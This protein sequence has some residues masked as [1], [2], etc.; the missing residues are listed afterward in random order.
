MTRYILESGEEL[1]TGQHP[2]FEETGGLH[3][4]EYLL[5]HRL[6]G[7][8][9]SLGSTPPQVIGS[10]SA[11]REDLESLCLLYKDNGCENHDDKKF[12]E[13]PPITGERLVYLNFDMIEV[14]KG[15]VIAIHSQKDS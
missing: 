13:Y 11:E 2:R 5:E 12:F 15:I 8:I 9:T 10:T 4:G 14:S 6:N 3:K 1:L 7:K